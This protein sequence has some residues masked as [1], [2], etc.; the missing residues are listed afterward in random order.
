MS[1]SLTET[2]AARTEALCAV[3]SPIGE[4]RA[5]CDAVEAWARPRAAHLRRVKDSLVLSF[6]AGRDLAGGG[7]GSPGNAARPLV[8]LCGHLDTIPVPGADRGKAP[9]REG[10]RLEIERVEVHPQAAVVA[11]FIAEVAF[12]G[13]KQRH[14]IGLHESRLRL[15]VQLRGI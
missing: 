1:T 15:S 12:P 10:G 7:P 2:L 3:P 6:D 8:L 5:L 4:E 11:R 13:R 14:Q 9:R